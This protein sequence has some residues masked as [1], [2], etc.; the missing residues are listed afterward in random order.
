MPDTVSN[1]CGVVVERHTNCSGLVIMGSADRRARE[2]DHHWQ[3]VL[4]ELPVHSTP[5]EGADLGHH[6][7]LAMG[8]YC[9][10]EKKACVKYRG[11]SP[12]FSRESVAEYVDCF[13]SC[14]LDAEPRRGQAQQRFKA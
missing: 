1:R 2:L 4:S 8:P 7:Q 5:P 11:L 13:G 6:Q 10:P 9:K 3:T 12:Y 14:G